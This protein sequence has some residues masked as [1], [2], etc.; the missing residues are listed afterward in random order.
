MSTSHRGGG[1][2]SLLFLNAELSTGAPASLPYK[3]LGARGCCD[4]HLFGR[5]GFSQAL[6]GVGVTRLDSPNFV[7]GMLSTLRC[8][9]R[10]P[11]RSSHPLAPHA[12][13]AE[14]RWD[15]KPELVWSLRQVCAVVG[16]NSSLCWAPMMH[17]WC[18]HDG[19]YSVLLPITLQCVCLPKRTEPSRPGRRLLRLPVFP[20]GGQGLTPSVGLC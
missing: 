19:T 3:E 1:R 11:G 16:V 10:A 18:L 20:T 8:P 13:Q 6:Q 7:R 2:G 17:C 4:A 15:C 12:A 9:L 5:K 14:I